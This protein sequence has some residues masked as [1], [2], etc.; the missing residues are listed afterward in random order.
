MTRRMTVSER[1]LREIPGEIRIGHATD[2][3]LGSGVTVIVP[4]K[5]AVASV[6]IR[7]GS[8]GTRDTHL[9]LPEQTVTYIDALVLS[10]GSAFGLDA[11]GGVQAW[12]REQ[13]RGYP[14]DPYR[15][16][17]V[18]SGILFDLR[19]SGNK[20]WGRYSPYRELGFAACQ[21]LSSEP[22]EGRVGAATGAGTA[23]IPGGF[24]VASQMLP[25]GRLVTSVAV[26]NAIGS[27]LIGET[28]HFWAAPFERHAE[29][30]GLGLPNP[31]P[32]NALEVRTKGG[33]DIS[34]LAS[35]T[36]GAVLTDVPLTKAGAKRIA[37]MAHDGL[38]RAI[39]PAHTPADGDLIFCLSTGGNAAS[40]DKIDYTR[41]GTAAANTMCRAIAR[42]IYKAL[43]TE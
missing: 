22:E 16:P 5:P 25:D 38:A 32:S 36:L 13:G 34:I 15:I 21:K 31:W 35:T 9:L 30:G 28:R 6:D 24:G 42:G 20:D 17:I 43:Q 7:G 41:L 39:Y 40:E 27:P 8:P 12:L 2:S 1:A 29:Y 11:A 3:D 26:V 14:I 4:D 23:T 37:T 33:A 10:G 19:S 18:P